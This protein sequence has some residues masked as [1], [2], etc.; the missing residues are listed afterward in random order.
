MSSW[1]S[2]MKTT[3][4]SGVKVI[5]W[6]SFQTEKQSNLLLPRDL[7]PSLCC[8]LKKKR[9]TLWCEPLEILRL[10]NYSVSCIL[11]IL[12]DPCYNIYSYFWRPDQTRL[13]IWSVLLHNTYHSVSP[14]DLWIKPRTLWY[15]QGVLILSPNAG[16]FTTSLVSHSRRMR[17][18]G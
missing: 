17:L 14:S 16:E 13:I 18:H 3:F 5:Q 12:L 2:S 4:I 9:S 8:C 6:E 15:I 11:V 10:F 1:A 7:P